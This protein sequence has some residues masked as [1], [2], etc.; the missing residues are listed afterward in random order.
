MAIFI[1]VN[2]N[3]RTSH[4]AQ[5][6][7]ATFPPEMQNGL[8]SIEPHVRFHNRPLY[9]VQVSTF[10]TV[11]HDLKLR[12]ELRAKELVTTADWVMQV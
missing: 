1:E 9:D 6:E 8:A 7:V 11:A 3:F 12:L 4:G 10:A 2:L 5:I